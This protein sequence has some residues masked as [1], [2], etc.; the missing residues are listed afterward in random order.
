MF[1]A[2]EE[3]LVTA[4]KKDFGSNQNV[5]VDMNKVTGEIHV[6]AQRTVVEGE[7][8]E[9]NDMSLQRLELLTGSLRSGRYCGKR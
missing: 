9:G 8:E 5:R 4:Y 1:Q 7:P 2:V 6:Y 3:A